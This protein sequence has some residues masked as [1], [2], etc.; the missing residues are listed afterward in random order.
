MALGIDGAAHQGALESSELNR[1]G[2]TLAVLGTGIDIIYPRRHQA[3]AQ[4]ILDQGGA[5]ITEFAPGTSPQPSNFP[6]RNR[7]ISGL[8]LGVLV[9]EAATKSGSLTTARLA[10][11]QGREVL[12]C[13]VNSQPSSVINCAKVLHWWHPSPILCRS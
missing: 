13:P 10:L 9:V 7:I 4:Q 1:P 11:E 3:L 12:P 8:S 5:L 6:R 2:K